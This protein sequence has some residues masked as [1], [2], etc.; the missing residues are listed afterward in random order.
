MAA[1]GEAWLH[2]GGG[3]G[4][5]YQ[6]PPFGATP[7]EW[8]AFCAKHRNVADGQGSKPQYGID[9]GSGFNYDLFDQPAIPEESDNMYTVAGHRA[10]ASFG[11]S[12]M[13]D[14]SPVDPGNFP[15]VTGVGY[16]KGWANQDSLRKWWNKNLA[17]ITDGYCINMVGIPAQHLNRGVQ[18][19]NI[20]PIDGLVFTIKLKYQG[21]VIAAGVDGSVKDGGYFPLPVAN[22]FRKDKNEVIQIVLDSV[23]ALNADQCKPGMGHLED[24]CVMVAADIFCGMTGK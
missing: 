18:W 16:E 1:P 11:L 9:V 20:C 10:P 12:R 24:W 3:T 5:P 19:C 21:T 17:N 15:R 7:A 22:G 14:F 4:T 6:C 13:L 23:P 8:E 2:V